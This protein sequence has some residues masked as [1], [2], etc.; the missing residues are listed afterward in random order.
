MRDT[1][2]VRGILRAPPLAASQDRVTR[3]NVRVFRV[4]ARFT[5]RIDPGANFAIITIRIVLGNLRVSLGIARGVDNFDCLAPL[6][7]F[8]S[9]HCKAGFQDGFS[10]FCFGVHRS[11]LSGCS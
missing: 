11:M 1:S 2:R 8:V 6:D 3:P 4:L 10:G 7:R 9:D 5:V